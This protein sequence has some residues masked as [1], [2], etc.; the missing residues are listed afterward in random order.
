M[1]SR[2]PLVLTLA[3]A[4]FLTAGLAAADTGDVL[5]IGVRNPSGGEEASRETQIIAS[6]PKDTYGTRQS[7][8]GDG[9]G[10]IY[11]CRSALDA[12]SVA[13]I[14]DPK[15][16]TACMRV[17]NLRGGKAFDFQASS[18]RI[19][20][21]MQAGHT[22]GTPKPT[23]APFVTN[24]T[25][26]AV[27]LNADRVDGLN[28]SEI[29]AQA[30]AAAAKGGGGGG[31][32][33][34]TCPANTVLT[35]GGCIENAP[36]AAATYAAAAAACGQAGRRLVP[37]DVLLHARTLEGINLGAGEM[38]ADLTPAAVAVVVAV[39]TIV[40]GY[41]TVNDAGTIGTAPQNTPAPYRCITA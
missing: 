31:G 40:E 38:S 14:A 19:I 34:A 22:L 10:A 17:N 2:T 1:T 21:I 12:T 39:A 23:V 18:G 7:N 3:A 8:K 20:G 6:T 27:G 29:I 37:P 36:R 28:A 26:V 16:S 11:G 35:G 25:G 32:T 30:V 5:N 41:A 33:P 24:A 9:G 13:S 15:K 4:I